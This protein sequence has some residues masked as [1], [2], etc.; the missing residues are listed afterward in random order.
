MRGFARAG[1]QVKHV[2]GIALSDL[3]APDLSG[4]SIL[5]IE[6]N[7]LIAM[8]VETALDEA[9]A[10]VQL[11]TT[12]GAGNSAIRERAEDCRLTD[13]SIN[14]RA[15]QWTIPAEIAHVAPQ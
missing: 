13:H 14:D 6:D 8:E 2:K 1:R 12:L 15:R 5:L 7:I 11:C 4:K 3:K 10:Q 9:G